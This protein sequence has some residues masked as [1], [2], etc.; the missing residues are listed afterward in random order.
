MG[1]PQVE[2]MNNS[3]RGFWTGSQ[4]KISIFSS[5]VSDLHFMLY[6]HLTR[7]RFSKALKSDESLEFLNLAE[8]IESA[9]RLVI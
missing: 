3:L 1:Q 5:F 8:R 9:V 7:E 6:M 2:R 4:S